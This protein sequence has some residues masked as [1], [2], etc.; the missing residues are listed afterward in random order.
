MKELYFIALLPPADLSEQI[1]QIRLQCSEKF[2]VY[3]ALRPPVHITLYPPF[4]FEEILEKKLIHII[5]QKTRG[6]AVFT[7]YL[8][9][10]G[11][12]RKEV[13]FIKAPASPELTGLQQTV[14]ALFQKVDPKRFQSP[15][16][17]PHITIAYRDVRP[18]TFNDIWAEYKNQTYS[19]HFIAEHFTLLKH[20]KIRWNAV[21]NFELTG[22]ANKA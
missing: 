22:P 11:H 16:F 2:G 1:H 19:A 13:V 5:R 7:Q 15:A 4:R 10:F 6:Q 8:K 3:K 12:F 20:D 14:S 21:E 18:E 9:D 17:H